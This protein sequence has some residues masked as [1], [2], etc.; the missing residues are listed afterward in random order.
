MVAAY[1][2]GPIAA[3][4]RRSAFAVKLADA[5]AFDIDFFPGRLDPEKF[6]MVHLFNTLAQSHHIVFR[7]VFRCVVVGVTEKGGV[8]EL[9]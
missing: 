3:R 7:R 4:L 2:A 5:K 6:A 9:E 1:R 8:I